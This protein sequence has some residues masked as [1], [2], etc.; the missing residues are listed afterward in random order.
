MLKA[1]RGERDP[2]GILVVLQA[3]AVA[4]GGGVG[5]AEPCLHPPA[6][7]GTPQ[8]SA[9]GVCPHQILSQRLQVMGTGREE[10]THPGCPVSQSSPSPFTGTSARSSE[11]EDQSLPLGLRHERAW[12][13]QS[14]SQELALPW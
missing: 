10:E 9:L 11:M 7:G 13:D 6:H 8:P 3:G 14:C 2:P 4:V 12:G 1:E 5:Q